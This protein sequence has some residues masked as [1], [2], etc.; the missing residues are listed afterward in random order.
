MVD[1]F[2]CSFDNLINQPWGLEYEIIDKNFQRK[3]GEENGTSSGNKKKQKK[4]FFCCY[5]YFN[6]F[7]YFS[8]ITTSLDENKDNRNLL[9][10]SLNQKL[11]RDEIE[12]MKED[13]IGEVIFNLIRSFRFRIARMKKLLKYFFEGNY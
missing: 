5:F 4:T 10:A 7:V 13:L 3:K 2:K 6:C 11:T 8:A 1:R 9:D 12:E